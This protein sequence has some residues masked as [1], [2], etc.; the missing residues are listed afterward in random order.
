[1]KA[2]IKMC[3]LCRRKKQYHLFINSIDDICISCSKL[4]EYETFKINLKETKIFKDK[5]IALL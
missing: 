4:P 1:M 5:L 3:L 2:K